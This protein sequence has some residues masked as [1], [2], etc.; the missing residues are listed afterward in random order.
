MNARLIRF[1]YGAAITLRI[2]SALF[3]A[4]MPRSAAGKLLKRVLREP[5]WA[6]LKS[7]I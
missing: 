5:Y 2:A 7:R 4:D 3:S 1:L 6:D